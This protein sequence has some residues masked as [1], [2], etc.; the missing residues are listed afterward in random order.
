MES[1]WAAEHL[2]VIRTLME[3]S[4]V[5]RRALAPI[6]MTMA[7]SAWRRPAQGGRWA[8]GPR[9]GSSCFG[10]RWR[11]CADRLVAAG[12]APGPQG[13]RAFLVAA[14]PA[15]EPGDAAAFAAG[16]L[17]CAGAGAA[18]GAG[19]RQ[20]PSGGSGC[21]RFGWCFTVA[22]PCRRLLHAARHEAVRLDLHV[23]GCGCAL[24][25]RLRACLNACSRA[26]CALAS[27]AL[28]FGGFHLAYGVYLY[29]TE[30]RE[31]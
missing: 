17:R 31:E 1:N 3:R 27:W 28:F 16:L 12:P 20:R 24:L 18:V 14:D 7:S 10:R 22:P 8:L 11:G 30:P 23:L 13:R 5:Y 26:L 25:L 6:M 19:L 2:Q 9:A 21:R 4:A 15:G 29:F